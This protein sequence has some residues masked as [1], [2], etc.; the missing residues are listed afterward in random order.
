MEIP[1]PADI[2][3]ALDIEAKVF[4][5]H[6]N[7]S[8]EHRIVVVEPGLPPHVVS[9][10]LVA[11]EEKRLRELIQKKQYD[12]GA[13]MEYDSKYSLPLSSL[14]ANR[15]K[16]FIIEPSCVPVTAREAA[17]VTNQGN[18]FFVHDLGYLE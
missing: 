10:G 16:P 14:D 9:Y 1:S 6:P 3:V 4:T 5:K 12:T 11:G 2:T 15:C 8:V 17:E 7:G 18:V 13:K